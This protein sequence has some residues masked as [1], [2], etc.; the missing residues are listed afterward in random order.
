MTQSSLQTQCPNCETRFRVT[1]EQLSIAGGKVRCGSCMKVFNAVEHQ[2]IKTD[3][4]STSGES[5]PKEHTTPS[6]ASPAPGSDPGTDEEDFVFADNPEEDAAEGRYAGTSL[7]FSEDELSDSFR[8]VAESERSDYH[9]DDPT[10]EKHAVDE[11]WAEAMLSDDHP[12]RPPEG[13]EAGEPS[14]QPPKPQ[15]PQEEPAGLQPEPVRPDDEQTAA[16]ASELTLAAT[17]DDRPAGAPEPRPRQHQ[18]SDTLYRDLRRDPVSVG[19]GKSRLR[20]AL[21]TLVVLALLGA[22]VAQVTWFQFDRLSAIP[23][24]RP[25]YEKGCELAGCQLKPLINVDAIQS[26]KL[27]VRTDPENRNQLIVDAVIINRAGFVQPFPAIALTFS[28]LNGDVVAQS[29]FLPE[30]YLAGDAETMDT[31]PSETPV[32]IAIS[33]RDPGRDAVNYNLNFRPWTP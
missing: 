22:L 9:D 31:M 2:V 8:G 4:D 23:Q 27:V 1:D 17:E 32:R 5:T 28:N 10:S 19:N 24:L 20:T 25:F 12:K 3:R 11:S 14:P 21:W 13:P 30:D 18:P 33:I 29:T 15:P 7:T 26:R 16:S 6:G